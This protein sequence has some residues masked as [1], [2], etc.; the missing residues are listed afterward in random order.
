VDVILGTDNI[1]DSLEYYRI[2]DTDYGSDYRLIALTVRLRPVWEAL[3]RKRRLYKNAD[4]DRIREV[5]KA[6]LEDVNMDKPI[7]ARGILD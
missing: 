7:W 5:V 6:S 3:K 2:Y 4:W 1:L